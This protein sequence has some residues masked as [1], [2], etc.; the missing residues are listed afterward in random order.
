MIASS[1][2]YVYYDW[3]LFDM[4]GYE[5]EFI[6]ASCFATK[7]LGTANQCLLF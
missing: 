4:D 2:L 1:F 6:N 5:K 7:A 3:T